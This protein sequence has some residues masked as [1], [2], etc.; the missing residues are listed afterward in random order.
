MND[1]LTEKELQ[2][3]IERRSTGKTSFVEFLEELS[4]IGVTQYM[5]NAGTGEATYMGEHAELKTDP[6]VNFVIANDF[7]RDQALQAI[8][9]ITI[10]FL[11]FLRE[12]ANAGIT[13]Y[14]VN[15]T[16]KKAIYHA[17]KGEQIVE[18]L[19]L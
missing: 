12:I 14:T 6:Q 5:I 7:N 13:S 10:P 2:D 9:N 1:K 15:I 3:I 19:Q 18:P 4:N 8:R 17:I 16:D 11:D